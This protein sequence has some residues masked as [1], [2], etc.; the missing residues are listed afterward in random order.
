MVEASEGR[1]VEVWEMVL[2]TVTVVVGIA[3]VAVMG[4]PVTVDTVVV[5]TMIFSWHSTSCGYW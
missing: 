2:V 3:A 1:T 5:L 4:V